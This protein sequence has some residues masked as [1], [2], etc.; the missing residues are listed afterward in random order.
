MGWLRI[1]ILLFVALTIA[2][3]ALWF[4]AQRRQRTR[5]KAQHLQNKN[6]V[7]EKEYITTEMERFNRG[8]KPKMLLLVYILPF[9]L[10]LFLLYLANI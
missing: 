1:L 9:A 3:V 7:S 4:K 10:V 2:Y 6:D 8:L 5:L